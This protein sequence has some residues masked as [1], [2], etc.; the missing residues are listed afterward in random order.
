MDN[1]IGLV[2]AGYRRTGKKEGVIFKFFIQEN[3]W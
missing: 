2:Q 1:F 3:I